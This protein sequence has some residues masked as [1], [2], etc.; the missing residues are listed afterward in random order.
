MIIIITSI[1]SS[2]GTLIAA[3]FSARSAYLSRKS[4]ETTVKIENQKKEDQFVYDLNRI[5]Q[6]G[7][8]YPYLENKTFTEKWNEFRHTNDEHYLRYDMYCNLI[9]NFLAQLY[10][11]YNK[12]KQ[13]V[14][15]F[16]D[17]K[18]WIRLHKYNWKNPVDENENIDGYDEDFRK[19]INSYITT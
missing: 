10:S 7:I 3:I 15:C 11:Y 4:L 1:I 14:E 17:V 5:I 2:I 12:D 8:E 18:S 9:F 13:K 6:I 19:F 16:V